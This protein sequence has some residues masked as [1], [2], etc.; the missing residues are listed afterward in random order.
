MVDETTG[1]T[2]TQAD[3][4]TQPPAGTS[5]TQADGEHGEQV[6]Q[7][8]SISLEE[9]KKLRSEANSLRRRLKDF[10]DKAKADEDAKLSEQE[11]SSKRIADLEGLLARRDSDLKERTIRSATVVEAARLG[12]ADPDDALRLLDPTALEFD[13]DGNPKNVASELAALAKSKPYLLTTRPAGSFD[14]G[15]GGGR[16]AGPATY[17]REQL[18][19][20]T[21]YAQHRDDIVKAH[22]EGRISG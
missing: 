13:D 10:E 11:R 18:K 1:A 19:D 22:A 14:T 7:P 9:A 16:S 17:T 8:E 4:G 6:T 15:L 21:F 12:F 5:P 3:P 20:P 2:G